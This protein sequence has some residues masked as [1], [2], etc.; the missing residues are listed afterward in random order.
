MF[1]PTYIVDGEHRIRAIFS[2]VIGIPF[3][4]MLFWASIVFLSSAYAVKITV[5]GVFE[6]VKDIE[7]GTGEKALDKNPSMPP[8]CSCH[9]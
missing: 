8:T 5:I 9:T 1:C 6:A 2:T 7:V 4:V 3:I